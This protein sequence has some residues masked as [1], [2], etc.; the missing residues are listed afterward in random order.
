[1]INAN[2]RIF[3]GSFILLLITGT[4]VVWGEVIGLALF[5]SR[6]GVASLPLA[7][8]AEAVLS[9]VLIFSFEQ[10]KGYVHDVFLVVGVCVA[11]I[12]LV[13]L[14]WWLTRHD[15]DA[16]FVSY[17]I[18]QRIL[19]DLL[20]YY[21]WLYLTSYY[22][23]HW[24]YLLTRLSTYAQFGMFGSGLVLAVLS[25]FFSTG[26]LVWFWMGSLVV[27][28]FALGIFA[29]EFQ[30][31]PRITESTATARLGNAV[32]SFYNTPMTRLLS[33]SALCVMFLLTIIYFQTLDIFAQRFSSDLALIRWLSLL[34]SF[35][36]LLVLPIQHILMPFVLQ[37][38]VFEEIN[39]VYPL[40]L[41]IAFGAVLLLPTLASAILGEFVRSSL[42]VSL[43]DTLQNQRKNILPSSLRVWA[44]AF[45]DGVV[46]PFGRL[47]GG[48]FL[49]LF[50]VERDLH[51]L[52]LGVGGIVLMGA[53]VWAE[54]RTSKHY[55]E[56][57]DAS[58]ASRQYGFLR[59]S[60]QDHLHGNA[61]I[62]AQLLR[63]LK[64][65]STDDREILLIAE[66]LAEIDSQE[67]FE[68]LLSIWAR[69]SASV[70][71]ELLLLLTEGWAQQR[72]GQAIRVLL[73]EALECDENKLRAAALQAMTSYP[74][75]LDTYRV[76]QYLIDKDPT[77][78]TMA[79]KLLLQHPAPKLA[80]AAHAQLN[81]LSRSHAAPTRALAVEA[82]VTGGMTS[83]GERVIP[84]EVER[85]QKDPAPRVRMS[86]I[87]AADFSQLIESSQDISPSVRQLA[88]QRLAQHPR[89][90]ANLLKKS[91]AQKKITA[92]G[93]Y[94]IHQVL[95]YWN[96][97]VA[98][99]R[100]NPGYAKT[101]LLDEVALGLKQI[102]YLCAMHKTLHDLHLPPLHPLLVELSLLRRRLLESVL[103][104]IGAVYGSQHLQAITRTIQ[105]ELS[106]SAHHTLVQLTND[107]IARQISRIL[108]APTHTPLLLT[109]SADWQ[110]NQPS[111][112]IHNLLAQTD[113]WLPLITL[114]ALV[115]L[116][117]T[118]AD[119][120]NIKAVIERSRKSHFDD[121]REGA[122][123][124]YKAIQ[125]PNPRQ[126]QERLSRIAPKERKEEGLKLLST[127]ERMLFLRNVK[128]F[129]NLR[130]DQLR[131]LARICEELSLN[132]GEYVI[133]KGDAGDN[134]F[135]VVE[136]EVSV[137]DPTTQGEHALLAVRKPGEVLGEISLFDGGL[138]S[139]DAVARTPVLLLIVYRDTLD[140][141]LAD[142]P[143][144]ALDMLRAMAHLIRD[145]DRSI[146]GLTRRMSGEQDMLEL[147]G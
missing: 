108:T 136:G 54:Y 144:I 38:S 147:Q 113:E 118:F 69:A 52:G 31:V 70:K 119:P 53:Y 88:V 141:A 93:A 60:L 137:I 11:G 111:D 77:V 130:L 76:A 107:T 33:V 5:I 32:R 96:L 94:Q 15:S 29:D 106:V 83:Y 90:S 121:I 56:S 91:L 80:R 128:F 98:L 3:W 61:E 41:G 4:A 109:D 78:A 23:S 87:E 134:L 9:I 115:A 24:R 131:T 142:D 84:V 95:A 7:I 63:R 65:L 13:L 135:I 48:V 57:L 46:K 25:L 21:A 62:V 39:D 73:V 143:G 66:A 139:A 114:Y 2:R 18:T 102:D 100:V 146:K 37:F 42:R 14:G 133:R 43:F 81:W 92:P 6:L 120:A 67:G 22:E 145:R 8:I 74:D 97:M 117:E 127:I 71:A 1:M 27:S 59:K 44:H 19:R 20:L 132:E 104:F 10:I 129:E 55:A 103:D 123:L 40:T 36:S 17:Y 50:A 138:R 112:I 28:A 79:A 26:E 75:L 99:G 58:L 30:G 49:A 110:P 51:T 86:V 72:S 140:S 68:T 85:F 105:M 82:L 45:L 34:I 125:S 101:I 64:E 126:Q 122:R 116:P 89:S 35:S 47:L 124:L 16:G 12:M